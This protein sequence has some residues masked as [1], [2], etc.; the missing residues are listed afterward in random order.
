MLHKV[1]LIFYKFYIVLC[2]SIHM[3]K[4]FFREI[5]HF[6]AVNMFHYTIMKVFKKS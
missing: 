6:N 4:V 5:K 3:Q 1:S 2:T